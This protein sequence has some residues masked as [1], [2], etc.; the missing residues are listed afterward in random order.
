M[1]AFFEMVWSFIMKYWVSLVLVAIGIVQM[2]IAKWI[3]LI[4]LIVVAAGIFLW[5]KFKK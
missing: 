5:E 3:I 1:K 4:I 2:F